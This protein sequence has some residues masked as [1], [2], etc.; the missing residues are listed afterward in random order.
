MK[1]FDAIFLPIGAYA[2]MT[3][4]SLRHNTA[5]PLHRHNVT[6]KKPLSPLRTTVYCASDLCI[7]V[8]INTDLHYFTI[9]LI[10]K[11]HHH[12]FHYHIYDQYH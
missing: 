1:E 8:F 10:E 9:L 2:L 5:T 12:H 3:L 7:S 6:G 4:L 11:H